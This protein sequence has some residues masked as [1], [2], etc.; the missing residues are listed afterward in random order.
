MRTL[1]LILLLFSLSIRAFSQK[2]T[3]VIRI[4]QHIHIDGKLEE[5]IWQSGF[6]LSDFTQIR[7]KPGLPSTEK[8]AVKVLY[9]NHSLYVAAK[10]FDNPAHI[11]S[12]LSLRDD[13]N[14]NTDNFQ[15]ILDT[16][17]DGQNGF[18]FGV[19]S[20]GVQYD[21]KVYIDDRSPELNM[22]WHS[23]V[24]KTDSGWTLEMRIPY[25]AFRFPKAT[26]SNWGINFSRYISRN[27]EEAY[28]N[29][30]KPDLDN[31]VVQCG[32]VN[33]IEGVDPPL[34][35]ALIPYVSSYVDH[36]PNPNTNQNLSY[37]YNGGMD[38]KY[39]VNEAFTL[40]MTLVP[41]FGQVVF[42]NQILNLSPFEVQFNENRQFFTEGT[43]LFNKAG[44]FYSRR[45]GLQAPNSV[46]QTLL[47][48]TEALSAI[49][50]SPKLYN[51]SKFS[52]RNKNGLGIGVFNGITAP[53]YATAINSIDNSERSVLV[54]P[55]TNYNVMVFDQNLK[56]NSYVTLTNT[57]VLR[58]G[59]FYDANV[60]GVNSKFNTKDNT[61]FI[62][63]NTAFS[64]KFFND[65]LAFGH[66][67]GTT[68]G[69]QRGKWIYSGSYFEESNTFDPNDLGFNTNNNKRI[70]NAFFS[71][72]KFN[73]FWKLN[74]LSS[75]INISHNRLYKPNVYTATYL[76]GSTWLTNRKF[77]SLSHTYNA[78]V[79]PSYDYFEPRRWGAV[80]E[81][82][83]W[84]SN[85]IFLSSNYQKRFA[86]DAG[87]NHVT[88]I[89]PGWR[90]WGYSFSPRVRVSDKLF[91]IYSW[92]QR[93][94]LG[95]QGYAVPFGKP[96]ERYDGILFGNRDQIVTTNTL[97]FNFTL[98]NR[99]GINFR[100]RH[101]RASVEYNYFYKL[102]NSGKLSRIEYD[103][104][105]VDGE[106]VFNN[107]YNAIT[108]DMVY[109][110]VFL[111][112]SEVNIVWKNA[113]FSSD[114]R[115]NNGYLENIETIL[116]Y[117]QQL[118]SF[119]IRLLY[120]LD[121][122]SLKRR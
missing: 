89:R 46:I 109:S 88:I 93:Y 113:I 119:S 81:R 95:S 84:I 56:N 107:N 36:Y 92:E 103:G 75:N 6:E 34:R 106:N 30:V 58:Q 35:L 17:H 114:R 55:V 54:S 13:F 15:I 19:S 48:P 23:A 101:Y 110:W 121:Y 45:I 49:P 53:Q 94:N 62:S 22:V 66:N 76:N 20:M 37:S 83:I 38:I 31:L 86:L 3:D 11:S 7:P 29:P 24:H 72:R 63:T 50:Q 18:I 115:V 80:F 102:E 120:W 118:N 104:L 25:S 60:T 1:Y 26:V 98:T 14:A 111:P 44:L 74:S 27:R 2:E 40:D 70:I 39:G 79:T 91:V 87:I 67:F 71:Y 82:P 12:I 41:D 5:E 108:I 64:N 43:E 97:N 90:E 9:D 57:N 10:C 69:K 16:Y 28:W 51:A 112:G 77:H 68:I 65:S 85:R 105:N 32:K 61:Y 52:G 47:S 8:T 122:E 100:L 116:G 117:P 59:S 73:P 33:G 78:S 96:L 99:M 4:N 21:A 42:D